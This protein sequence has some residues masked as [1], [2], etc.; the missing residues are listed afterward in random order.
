MCIK[1]TAIGK[2][3]REDRRTGCIA[4]Q[5]RAPQ[6]SGIPVRARVQYHTFYFILYIVAFNHNLPCLPSVRI[7]GT[8]MDA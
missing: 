5:V 7:G 8:K 3:V 4:Q 6:A 2:H 1:A